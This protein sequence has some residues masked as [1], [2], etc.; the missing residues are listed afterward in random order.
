MSTK[1]T[2]VSKGLKYFALALPLLFGAPIIITMGFKA[3]AKNNSYIILIVGIV[4]ALLAIVVTAKAV[5]ST[6]KS[7]FERDEE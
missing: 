2:P 7:I 3:L 5:M 1:K 4:L 6:M